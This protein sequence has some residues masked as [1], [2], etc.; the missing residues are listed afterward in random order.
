M[1]ISRD[2]EKSFDKIQRPFVTKALMKLG[3]EGMYL[4]KVKAIYDKPIATS[5]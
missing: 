5:Y 4:N 3:V 2:A 1:S